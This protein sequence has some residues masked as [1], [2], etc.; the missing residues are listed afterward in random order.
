MSNQ[1]SDK[2]RDEIN[3]RNL[4]R[5]DDS[6]KEILSTASAVTVYQF[7]I[8]AKKWNKLPIEGPLHVVRRSTYPRTTLYVMNRLETSNLILPI[9]KETDVKV[10]LPY[11]MLKNLERGIFCI[12]FYVND[13]CAETA[14]LLINELESL[15]KNG[16]NSGDIV[17]QP[18]DSFVDTL[19]KIGIKNVTVS[20]S[21]SK[22]LDS[23]VHSDGKNIEPS[24]LMST[25]SN[26]VDKQKSLENGGRSVNVQDLFAQAASLAQGANVSQSSIPDS[27][28]TPRA[29]SRNQFAPINLIY[30]LE[31]AK[32]D[33]TGEPLAPNDT[34]EDEMLT[35]AMIKERSKDKSLL[36]DNEKQNTGILTSSNDLVPP[37]DDLYIYGQSSK[38]LSNNP[39][40]SRLQLSASTSRSLPQSNVYDP[41]LPTDQLKN[42]LIHLIQT[43]PEFVAKIRA[44]L[45]ATQ[46]QASYP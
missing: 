1:R 6:I 19:A 25:P 4:R 22:G 27:R 13:E 8:D 36:Q 23:N 3:L 39:N 37:I 17:A 26:S 32:N 2:G 16:P 28:H 44:A 11:L 34:L 30:D 45:I 5:M 14:S 29:M 33:E 46:H 42:V 40:H 43:D 15:T 12:W 35:P 7:A 10:E 18:V 9:T 20:K 41:Q 24:E 21:A 31:R 38:P